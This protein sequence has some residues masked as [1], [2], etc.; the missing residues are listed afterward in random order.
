MYN[1]HFVEQ[2]YT[3]QYTSTM[4]ITPPIS[5]TFTQQSSIYP[6]Q[7]EQVV[8]DEWKQLCRGARLTNAVP[9]T[10]FQGCIDEVP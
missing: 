10:H 3:Q 5:I 2:E 4:Q 6:L 9:F 7:Y 1:I 8:L